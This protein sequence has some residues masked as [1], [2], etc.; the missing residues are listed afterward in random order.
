M[1]GERPRPGTLDHGDRPDGGILRDGLEPGHR[2]LGHDDNR[3]LKAAE[4]VA[5]YNLGHDVPFTEYTWQSGPSSTPPHVGWQTHT[6][7][8]G[9]AR[10][11]QRPVWELILAHYAGRRGLEAPWVEEMVGTL[12]PE[13]GGGDYGDTSGGYDQLG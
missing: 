4:Y 10:G 2:L 7:I 11:Q 3:F 8:S 9:T 1:A 6:E 13:G 12:R 5:K